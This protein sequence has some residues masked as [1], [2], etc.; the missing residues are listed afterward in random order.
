MNWY[1]FKRQESPFGL[2]YELDLYKKQVHL[3]MDCLSASMSSSCWWWEPCSRRAFRS[4]ASWTFRS[5]FC[6]KVVYLK[7]RKVIQNLNHCRHFKENT[8]YQYTCNYSIHPCKKLRF[9]QKCTV[10]ILQCCKYVA[11]LN[12]YTCTCIILLLCYMFER[13]EFLLHFM[14]LSL[15]FF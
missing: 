12:A 4:S 7:H 1:I 5:Y 13:V 2:L 9:T 6:L 10:I 14:Q 3:P 11:L 8:L 15:F